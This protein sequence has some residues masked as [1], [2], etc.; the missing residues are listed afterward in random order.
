MS[1]WFW[2]YRG[3]LRIEL[4][5]PVLK[6]VSKKANDPVEHS[7]ILLICTKLPSLFCLS[8]DGLLRQVSVSF[9]YRRAY[10]A[11]FHITNL[12]TYL[13]FLALLTVLVT[14]CTFEIVHSEPPSSNSS[15]TTLTSNYKDVIS[16]ERCKVLMSFKLWYLKQKINIRPT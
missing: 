10:G 5:A 2:G 6:V 3:Y 8:L 16:V 11:W 4:Q 15:N 14:T 12:V 13:I 1:F 9:C 7:A